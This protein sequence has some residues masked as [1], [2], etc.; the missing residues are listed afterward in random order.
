MTIIDN[1]GDVYHMLQC[2]YALKIEATT[3]LRH[4]RG[5]V[6]NLVRTRYG[7]TSRTKKGAMEQLAA[8][9]AE[10]GHVL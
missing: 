3:G 5:S 2:Y 1:P 7:I 10:N 6:L 8:K 9:L 4:S